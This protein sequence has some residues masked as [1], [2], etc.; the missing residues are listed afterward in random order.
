[1]S[2]ALNGI[3]L[4]GLS[5]LVQ[6]SFASRGSSTAPISKP[7]RG[8]PQPKCRRSG[9]EHVIRPTS[10]SLRVLDRTGPLAGDLGANPWP[11]RITAQATYRPGLGIYGRVML[12]H[13]EP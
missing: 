10:P 9:Q 2:E 11:A 13:E 12:C 6:S 4:W 8:S 7:R 3:G 1:M 5:G